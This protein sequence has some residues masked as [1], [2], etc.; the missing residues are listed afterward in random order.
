MFDLWI[1]CCF[2][3]SDLYFMHIQDEKKFNN[4]TNYR[5]RVGIIYTMAKA[6]N[7]TRKLE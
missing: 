2:K 5:M 7:A 3:Y 4:Y 6:S 1:A